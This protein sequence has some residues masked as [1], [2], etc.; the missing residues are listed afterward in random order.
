MTEKK[1]CSVA[2]KRLIKF[3]A[4]QRDFFRLQNENRSLELKNRWLE[5]QNK[6]WKNCVEKFKH[7][8]ELN[9]N[10]KTGCD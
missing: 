2:R 3:N 8:L 5:T 6:D 4:L 1:W 9:I 7:L 10:K